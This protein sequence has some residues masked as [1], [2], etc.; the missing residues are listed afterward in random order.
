MRLPVEVALNG[1]SKVL[2][3]SMVRRDVPW[4]DGV[5]GFKDVL[6]LVGNTYHLT[7]VRVEGY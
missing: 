4:M 3:P 7:L 6:A 2:C 1:D 5:L